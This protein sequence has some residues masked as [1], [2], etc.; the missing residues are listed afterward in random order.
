MV[1]ATRNSVVIVRLR[2]KTDLGVTFLEVLSRY[3][4]ALEG[5]DSK[6]MVVYDDPKVRDQL[7][8]TGAA[9]ALGADGIYESDEWL[10]A[11]VKRAYRD[12]RDWI[13]ANTE[14]V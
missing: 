3:A 1:S 10:G 13:A 14:S 12:A 11:T 7:E 5:A 8:A 9:A 6:L 4:E 2:G